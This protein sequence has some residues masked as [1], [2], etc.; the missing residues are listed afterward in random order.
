MISTDDQQNQYKEFKSLLGCTRHDILRSFRMSTFG[1]VFN[2]QGVHL[3]E[4][5]ERANALF[6]S[7]RILNKPLV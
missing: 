2:S 3:N 4:L 1:M 6:E 5:A 7:L